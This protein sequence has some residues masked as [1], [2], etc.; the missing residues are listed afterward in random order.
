MNNNLFIIAGPCVIEDEAI[1]L[2]IAQELKRISLNLGIEII[3]KASYD[4]ANRSSVRSFRGNGMNQGLKILENVKVATGLKLL[5]D[6]H[7]T[8]EVNQAA[9]VLDVIQIP[10][11]LCRQTDL[12][13]KA[14]ATNKTVNIKKGQF[15]APW[16]MKNVIDKAVNTGNK[17]VWITERGTTFGYNNLVVDFRSL[18]IM[19]EWGYPVIFDATHSVQ[20][21]G[22]AGE[23]SSGQREFVPHLT[24]AA[25][26]CGV[27]GLFMEVHPEPEKALSDGPNMLYLKDVELLLKE[28]LTINALPKG[29]YL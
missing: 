14:A 21:P 6:V 29:T 22:G 4:K 23:K 24:R 25:V 20:L 13:L 9:E 15:L 17:N 16:D 5:S 19:R 1:T 12:L 7:E 27:D 3:F 26:A 10:A 28:A 18:V 2:E 8:T 11:F